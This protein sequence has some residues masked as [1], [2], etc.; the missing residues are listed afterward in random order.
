MAYNQPEEFL[1]LSTQTASSSASLSFTSL[2]TSQYPVYYIKVRNLLPVS[3]NVA[4]Q[5]LFS[6]N[7]GSTY[8]NSNYGWVNWIMYS[9]GTFLGGSGNLSASLIQIGDSLSNVSTRPF[10]G[11]YYFYNLATTNVVTMKGRAVK[12][13]QFGNLGEATIGGLN[14]GT[15]AVNAI[16]FSLT[17]GNIASGT[18]SIYGMTI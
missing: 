9:A 6:T 3:N 4:L 7:N 5:V 17:S 16:Q 18:I 15:T 1:L 12:Y 13:D 11:N 8:L 2:I 10:N 14:T